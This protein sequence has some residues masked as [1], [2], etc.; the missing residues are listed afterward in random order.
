MKKHIILILFLFFATL[1]FSQSNGKLRIGSVNVK[2]SNGVLVFSAPIKINSP[3]WISITDLD[4]AILGDGLKVKNGKLNTIVGR[5][6]NISGD[7][8]VYTGS[9]TINVDGQK[10]ILQD[11]GTYSI[12][13]YIE[14]D[15]IGVGDVGL[16]DNNGKINSDSLTT[17]V[18]YSASIMLPPSSNFDTYDLL[19]T[20]NT[21]GDP[22]FRT[23]VGD[24]FLFYK[25]LKVVTG[26]LILTNGRIQGNKGADVTADT[27]I[28]LGNGN[29][30]NLTT[31]IGISLKGIDNTN[32]QAGSQITLMCA[33]RIRFKHLDTCYDNVKPFY[34]QQTTEYITQENDVLTFIYDGEYWRE[35]SLIIG[36]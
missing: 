4:T 19:I 14:F 29:Y 3:Q 30:F 17:T 32:W 7:S 1:S 21:N 31:D 10:I 20:S 24:Y 27:T 25:T 9:N 5:G 16:R 11:D 12:S 15:S 35:I 18:L 8:I 2:D 33:G 6:L 13:N 23:T 36:S 22:V 26:D 34:M 28:V